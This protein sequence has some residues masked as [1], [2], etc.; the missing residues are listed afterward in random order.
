MRIVI[1]GYYGSKN[2]GDEAMLAAM[3]E[4]FLSIDKKVHITVVSA[5]PD[6]TKKRHG[7]AAVGLTDI[8]AIVGAIR[9]A[10][11]LISGGGSLLQNVTSG[12]SL[13]YYLGIIAGHALCSRHRPYLRAN[14]PIFDESF[15]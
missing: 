4:V 3:I 1:S 11:I 2:A 13:Y 15:G 14:G 6:D 12:R 7:V 5:N 8:F 9:K 10:D